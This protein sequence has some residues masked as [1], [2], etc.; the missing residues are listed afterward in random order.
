MGSV[1]RQGYRFSLAR[2][3]RAMLISYES[4]ASIA[5]APSA[6]S[7][8]VLRLAAGTCGNTPR[9]LVPAW[10]GHTGRGGHNACAASRVAHRLGD[11]AA[12]RA[13]PRPTE[14]PPYVQIDDRPERPPDLFPRLVGQSP[15][16]PPI[17]LPAIQ[18]AYS[19]RCGATKK[20]RSSRLWPYRSIHNS[21]RVAVTWQVFRHLWQYGKPYG[22]P[23]PDKTAPLRYRAGQRGSCA[24]KRQRVAPVHRWDAISL[25]ACESVATRAVS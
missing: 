19:P 25:G 1:R 5:R 23:R 17:A 13:I 6:A 7:L 20:A 14:P 18:R 8:P 3:D 22:A 12:V 9:W 15:F 10:A 2:L 11:V 21:L 4:L 16:A 24:A